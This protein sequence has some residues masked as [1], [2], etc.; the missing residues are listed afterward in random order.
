MAVVAQTPGTNASAAGQST[1]VSNPTLSF[2]LTGVSDWATAMPFL[3]LMKTSR[4]FMGHTSTTWSAMNNGALE[5]AGVFDANGWPK[6]IP[7][8]LASIGTIWDWDAKDL[9]AAA[10]RMGTYVVKYDGAGEI[11]LKGDVQILSQKDGEIVFANLKGGQI[12]LEIRSTDPLQTGD[13]IRDIT[14][15]RQDYQA[16]YEMGQIFNPQWL[17]L[18][19]DARELRFMDW[20][21]TNGVTSAAWEDRPQVGDVTYGKGGVPV[22]VMVALANQTGSEPWFTIPAGASED[23]IRNFATYVRDHLDPALQAHVEYSNET[24]NWAFGQTQWLAEQARTVW[25]SSDGGAWLDYHAMLATKSALIWDEVFGA[26][27][28][29]RLDHV[30]GWQTGNTWI[31]PRLM[32]AS[33]WK[34]MD[35]LGYVKP[36]S[37]FD[38]LGVTTYFGGATM[39]KAALRTELLE[40]I[41][42]DPAAAAAWLT[43]RL[44]DPAYADS[45]P[46]IA[47]LWQ[48]SKLAADKYGLD[49]VA[50]EG[51]QH[52]LQAF[53]IGT[54]PEAD[55][56]VLTRFLA[57]YIRS[58][59]MAVLYKALW[60]EWAK[61]S[62]GPFMQYGEVAA[63]SKWGA[64]GIYTHL[65]DDNPRAA[66]LVELNATQANWFEGATQ[67]GDTRYLQGVVKLAGD[68]AAVLVGTAQDDFLIGG[69]GAD[70]FTPGKG[71]DAIAGEGGRDTL[72]LQGRPQD[73]TLTKDGDM[74]RIAGLDSSYLI[75]SIEVLEFDGGVIGYMDHYLPGL[76]L[77]TGSVLSLKTLGARVDAS[78]AGTVALQGQGLTIHGIASGTSLGKQLGLVSTGS[79]GTGAET[80][81]VAG[82]YQTGSLAMTNLSAAL[83]QGSIVTGVKALRATAGNDRFFGADADDRVFGM[84]GN[85][86]LS[87]GAGRDRLDGGLGHDWL[88]GGQGN[89]ILR[90][91]AGVDTFVFAPGGG[92]DVITDFTPRDRLD[93]SAFDLPSRAALLALAG[94]DAAGNLVLDFG[95]ETLTLQGVQLADL[96]W[97]TAWL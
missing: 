77:P 6:S 96:S 22:E 44:Q 28:D 15:V 25:G 40:R 1:T 10:S 47:A 62:D 17:S 87:G 51:G 30:M 67:P 27:S 59:D 88:D 20:M 90:G 50:Y 11:R 39:A 82:A 3:D 23:Y 76:D 12:L 45:I 13:Y 14:M 42:A 43:E 61:V 91:G 2:G 78:A 69:K 55:Q 41:Q 84:V 97:V 5:A 38:S 57:A 53:A 71:H 32:T 29:A 16:L 79:M 80:A 37:V 35:P 92:Q 34:T 58:P 9:G 31:L 8:G 54:M 93:L 94:S 66:L 60:Q 95:V 64:W 89:D 36:S 75:R 86:R 56:A 33:V 81:L 85:D 18:I 21:K 68:K 24:W 72:V 49:L 65:G 26:S 52:L 73:Y 19:Q 46:Q 63:A 48:S 83:A 4:S 70:R 74:F 7:E